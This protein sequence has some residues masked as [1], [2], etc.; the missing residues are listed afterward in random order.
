MSKKIK[1]LNVPIH[2][3]KAQ[4]VIERIKNFIASGFPH[5]I[6]T[7][8]PEFVVEAQ[9]NR[10]F[11]RVLQNTELNIAD[12]IGIKFAAKFLGQTPVPQ[13]IPGVD[14]AEKIFALARQNNWR[15]F[16]LGG[17]PGVAKLARDIILVKYPGI[18][19]VGAEEGLHFNKNNDLAKKNPVIQ[20]LIAKIRNAKPHILLVAFGAPKQEIFIYKFKRELGVPVMI[21]V[22][23]T[24]D[25]ITQRAKRAPMTLRSWGLEWLW[26]LVLEPRR[27]GRIFNAIIVFPY[28]V[29]R[30][31]AK[32]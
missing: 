5:Q 15:I 31:K 27:L 25:F 4:D 16:L 32:W 3:L 6:A 14:L 9:H 22:G 26:R 7:V 23:G 11:N 18:I 1:I 12:G 2:P 29:L 24:F 19:I 10:T 30:D 13:V 20:Q 28:L 8:N 17:K 21:G